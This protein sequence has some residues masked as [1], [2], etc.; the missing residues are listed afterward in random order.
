MMTAGSGA[1]ANHVAGLIDEKDVI[2]LTPMM[3]IFEPHAVSA[4]IVFSATISTAST[5]RVHGGIRQNERSDGE[6]GRERGRW[7]VRQFHTDTIA[8]GLKRASF[9]R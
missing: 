2:M 9:E 3:I 8:N 1:F 6:S 7:F 5:V 4:A